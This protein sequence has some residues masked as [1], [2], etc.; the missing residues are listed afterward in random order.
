MAILPGILQASPDTPDA[1][2]SLE[3]ICPKSA[4]PAKTLWGVRI[5]DSEEAEERLPL[6]CLQGLVNRRQPQIYLAYFYKHATPNDV[7]VNALTGVGYMHVLVEVEKELG[8]DYVAVR[9]DHLPTLYNE[10]KKR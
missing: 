3:P 10:A 8:P 5:E 7:L 4:P 2:Q 1:R 6:A 9:A